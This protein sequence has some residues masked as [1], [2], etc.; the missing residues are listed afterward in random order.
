MMIGGINFT[1]I[2]FLLKFSFKKAYENNEFRVYL[3]IIIIFSMLISVLLYFDS[4]HEIEPAFRA[5]L[6]QVTTIVTTTG[7]STSN[8]AMWSPFAYMLIILL[9]FI[10]GS[11]GSTAGGVK[12]VRHLIIIKNAYL[13][14]RRLLHPRAVIPVRINDQ[15][16][17]PKNVYNVLAFFFIYILIFI[18]GALVISA[19]GYDIMT[20]AGASIAC[21]GNIGPGLGGVDPSHN[22]AFFSE[23]AQL[24]LSFLMLLGRLELFTVLI[25]LTP[26]FWNN[27]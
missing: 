8:Y 26:A 16:V 22:F 24:F 18:I 13:E 17:E 2:Y 5:A 25:L 12:V 20:A 7:F 19:F 6:F 1:I 21:L 10:G 11:A 27:V 3:G 4:I 14:F 23:G 9:M 15:S